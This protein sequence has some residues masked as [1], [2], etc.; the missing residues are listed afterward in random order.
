MPFKNLASLKKVATLNA[1]VVAIA[2]DEKARSLAAITSDPVQVAIQPI[3]AGTAKKKN[4]SIDE[5]VDGA[6]IDKRVALVK[7]GSDIWGLLDIQ[8]SPKIEQ[9]GRD[10]RSLHNNRRGEMA[11]AI[12]WDGQGAE[13]QIQGHEVGGRQF[14]LRGTVRACSLD[15]S[16]CYVVVDGP[17]GGRFREHRGST[18]ESGTQVRCD[19]PAAAQGMKT[20]AGGQQLS[21]LCKPGGDT[22]CVIRRQGAAD[23]SAKMIGIDTTTVDVAVIESSLFVL[24]VDGKLRLYDSDTLHR[25]GDDV[26]TPTCALD[27]RG[28]GVPTALASTTKGGNIL[29][30][31][32][33]EGDL[34]RCNAVGRGMDI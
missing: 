19:L 29:W 20:L 12:G 5:A 10:M 26:A 2:P 15:G 27:L 4:V 1:E 13:L 32:T 31:G 28:S 24:G 8:H 34:I 30:V 6:L 25:A 11:L 18:P 7:S 21:A 17:G 14:V 22:V 33:K 23:L 9:V 16:F 3:G